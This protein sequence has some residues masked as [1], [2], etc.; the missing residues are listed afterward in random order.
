MALISTKKSLV[1]PMTF[2]P[3]CIHG[4]TIPAWF[5]WY[6]MTEVCYLQQKNLIIKFWW[7]SHGQQ[8]QSVSFSASATLWTNNPKLSIPIWCWVFYLVTHSSKL[9]TLRIQCTLKKVGNFWIVAWQ[10][11]QGYCVSPHGKAKAPNVSSLNFEH[12]LP[13]CKNKN[14]TV[15]I[16]ES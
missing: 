5:S 2:M 8:Q 12:M 15:W 13:S 3:S 11:L 14:S 6:P 10:W 1:T 16:S 4:Y 7:T 9:T